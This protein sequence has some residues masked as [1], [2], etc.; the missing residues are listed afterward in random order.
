MENEVTFG[1]QEMSRWELLVM[2]LA[3]DSKASYS[4]CEQ[5]M[6][7]PFGRLSGRVAMLQHLGAC[8]DDPNLLV[9]VGVR[10]TSSPRRS[11]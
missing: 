5:K 4:F 2:V 6:T 3:R 8:E 9:F 1:D 11:Q 10:L 7:Y